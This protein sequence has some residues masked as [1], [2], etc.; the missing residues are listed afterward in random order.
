MA[1]ATSRSLSD[2]G[3][4]RVKIMQNSATAKDLLASDLPKNDERNE[5]PQQEKISSHPEHGSL[6][7]SLLGPSL[8]KSGQ[9]SV[10]QKKVRILR[11]HVYELDR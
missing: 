9:D 4:G 6:K 7:Y 1:S 11:K 10:D 8:T 3:H 5:P 2:D